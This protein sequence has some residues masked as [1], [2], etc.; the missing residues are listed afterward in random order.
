MQP[1]AIILMGCGVIIMALHSLNLRW[2]VHKRE[3]KQIIA[4][5]PLLAIEF[6]VSFLLLSPF[7]FFWDSIVG[8]FSVPIRPDQTWFW[9]GVTLTTFA[10]LVIQYA[11]AKAKAEAHGEVSLV[12]PIQA[13]TPGLITVTALFLGERL[14]ALGWIALLLI[15]GGVY[16]HA[17]W[18]ASAKTLYEWLLPLA[19]WIWF[20]P[21]R[22]LLSEEEKSKRRAL[23]WS[24]LGAVF[25][26]VGLLGDG[27]SARHGNLPLAFAIQALVMAVVYACAVPLT[28]SSWQVDRTCVSV[29]FDPRW[30]VALLGLLFA[31]H[32]FTVQTAF[33]LS[34]IAVIGTLKRVRILVEVPLARFVLGEKKALGRRLWVAILVAI[35]AIILALDDKS[36]AVF[37][38]LER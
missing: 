23:R 16:V 10:N 33:M 29:K 36:P 25:G 14:S 13:L 8:Y 7:I 21:H 2:L 35:G 4:E 24:Y 9:R 30:M 18:E 12:A 34:P 5:I 19:F 1:L 6:A 27:L 32:I 28:K 17:R 37:T 26:A 3:G 31:A 15:S 11:G 22:G 20:L 38:Y